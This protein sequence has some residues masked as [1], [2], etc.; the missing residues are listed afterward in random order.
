MCV[1]VRRHRVAAAVLYGRC[2][3]RGADGAIPRQAVRL[4][5]A[6]VPQVDRPR[7]HQGQIA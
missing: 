1:C 7:D 3:G 2:Q 5:I 6:R 4:H